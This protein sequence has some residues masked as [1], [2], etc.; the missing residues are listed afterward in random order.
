MRFAHTNIVAK[1]WKRLARF[2]CEVF[3]CEISGP[4]R[5]LH[6]TWL[7]MGSGIEGAALT[8]IHLNENCCVNYNE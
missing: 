2:Y 8:G 6:E 3:D 7:A 1:D 4:E 5:D